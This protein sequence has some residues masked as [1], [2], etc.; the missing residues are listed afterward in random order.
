MT[1]KETTWISNLGDPNAF[2]ELLRPP[3]LPAEYV[4]VVVFSYYYVLV[5]TKEPE[6]IIL[7]KQ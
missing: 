4:V 2:V 5:D 7:R 6:I 3:S 1:P